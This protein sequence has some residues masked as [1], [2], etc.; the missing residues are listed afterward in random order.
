MLPGGQQML[1]GGQQMLP[2]GQQMT[3]FQALVEEYAIPR[4]STF[5][6]A[7]CVGDRFTS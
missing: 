4:A 3:N 1:P 6:F 7:Q 2:G 5:K